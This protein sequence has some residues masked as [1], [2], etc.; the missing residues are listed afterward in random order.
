MD[1]NLQ[2]LLTLVSFFLIRIPERV[3]FFFFRREGKVRE[4]RK[5]KERGR[6][7]KKGKR[8]LKKWERWGEWGNMQKP[9]RPLAT[10]TQFPAAS[11]Q[12]WHSQWSQRTDA[13]QSGAPGL[14]RLYDSLIRFVH[15]PS[16]LVARGR[17]TTPP[18]RSKLF[19]FSTVIEIMMYKSGRKFGQF[20]IWRKIWKK[21]ELDIC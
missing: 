8:I 11:I 4:W 19:Y 5:I 9:W 18:L 17:E 16:F 12:N 15:F 2:N 13:L 7:K 14:F 20:S 3:Y 6:E 1:S 21:I 10:V